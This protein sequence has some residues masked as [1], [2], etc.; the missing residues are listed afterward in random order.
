MA[1]VSRLQQPPTQQDFHH[2]IGQRAS[3]WYAACLKITGSEAM[4][5]DA[6]QDALTSAWSKRRQFHGNSKLE[7]WIH[8]IAV[9]CALGLLRRQKPTDPWQHDQLADPGPSPADERFEQELGRDLNRAL[10]ALT[11]LERVCFVLKH[12]EQWRLS[13][14]A[15]KL[16]VGVDTVKQALFRAL[17]KLR[18]SMA[19][20]K[21][22]I[23]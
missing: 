6:V 12:L 22:G 2:A 16:G 7:T 23:S 21:A 13:E 5:Q 8:R 15:E 14:I 17:R 4:A 20:L 19:H 9:N 10:V 18:K 3:A 11:E 1:P